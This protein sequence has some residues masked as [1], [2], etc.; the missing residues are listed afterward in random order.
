MVRHCKH[1]EAPADHE[2]VSVVAP[3]VGADVSNERAERHDWHELRG[4]EED[5]HGLA[6]VVERLIGE[7]G[8]ERD[9]EAEIGVVRRHGAEGLSESG[10]WKG[11]IERHTQQGRPEPFPAP[12]PPVG[13]AAAPDPERE[14]LQEERPRGDAQ[15]KC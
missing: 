8:R 2:C 14:T 1:R 11:T 13:V 3:R 5:F 10:D 15:C 6:D 12:E 4:L 9:H 7:A